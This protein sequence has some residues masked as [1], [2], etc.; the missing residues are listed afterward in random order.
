MIFLSNKQPGKFDYDNFIS[1]ISQKMPI[2]IT[3][4]GMI[5]KLPEEML[6]RDI[7][8]YIILSNIKEDLLKLTETIKNLAH[9][10]WYRS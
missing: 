5:E 7:A 8:M 1:Q 9:H 2:I 3:K 10:E 6:N 4:F